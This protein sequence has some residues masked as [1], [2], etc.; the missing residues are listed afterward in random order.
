MGSS[1]DVENCCITFYVHKRDLNGAFIG[2]DVKQMLCCTTIKTDNKISPS[3]C[4]F[5]SGR[6]FN[7]HRLCKHFSL[8]CSASN[9][10]YETKT[11]CT[12]TSFSFMFFPSTSKLTRQKMRFTVDLFFCC[13]T[14]DDVACNQHLAKRR[15]Y[16]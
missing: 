6:I 13:C 16:V 2:L 8:L 11:N 7:F 1:S 12:E 14:E 15:I 10:T 5:Y 4:P 9:R 3:Q